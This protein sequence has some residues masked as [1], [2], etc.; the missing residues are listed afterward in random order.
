MSPRYG[1]VLLSLAALSGLVGCKRGSGE[2]SN[3]GG[4]Q[5]QA[6]PPGQAWNGQACVAQ[7]APPPTNTA[8]TTTTPPPPP[9]PT[10]TTGPN[11]APLDPAS[12]GAAAQGLDALAKQ[13]APGAKAVSGTMMAGQFQQGQIL[14]TVFNA[15]PGKCYTVVGAGLPNVQ[16]LDLQ[17]V[18]QSPV[19]GFGSPVLSVDQTTGPN[20]VAAPHPNCFKWAA[21]LAAPLKVVMTVSAGSGIAAAQVYEK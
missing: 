7:T 2:G 16:N 1:L 6:C 18:A 14:E 17:I 13:S 11:A 21:P 15:Q 9:V 10:G 8:T 19:P 20:A 3:V 12:A 4:P 5:P